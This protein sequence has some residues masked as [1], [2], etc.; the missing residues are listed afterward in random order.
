MRLPKY[1][2]LI[3]QS[4]NMR[5]GYV[6]KLLVSQVE[7]KERQVH[8]VPVEGFKAGVHPLRK[9]PTLTEAD[10]EASYGSTSSFICHRCPPLA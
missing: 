8:H 2:P 3:N 6:T 10:V 4:H 1:P 5:V 7:R 9:T